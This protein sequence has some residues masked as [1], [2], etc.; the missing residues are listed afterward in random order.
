MAAAPVEGTS[1]VSVLTHDC[2]GRFMCS[3]LDNDYPCMVQG[4]HTIDVDRLIKHEL[5]AP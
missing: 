4:K 1:G 2:S 5:R 3:R